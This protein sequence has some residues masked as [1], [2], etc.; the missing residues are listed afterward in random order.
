MVETYPRYWG[1]HSELS[2]LYSSMG[3]FQQAVE[4]AETA[5]RFEPR[6]ESPR[7]NLMRAYIGLDRFADAAKALSEARKIGFGGAKLH[8]IA[9]EAAYLREDAAA[10]TQE[11]AWFAGRPEEYL[12][13]GAQAV[14]ADAL[15]SR[16]EASALYQRAAELAQQHG[17][18]D[19]RDDYEDTNAVAEAATGNCQ[20]VA[21]TGRPALALALCGDAAGAEKLAAATSRQ[22]PNGTLWNAAHLPAIRAAIHIKIGHPEK[23]SDDLAPATSYERVS[24]EAPYLRAIAADA[25]GKPAEAEAEYRKLLDHPGANLGVFYALAR[26]KEGRRTEPS[27]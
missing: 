22:Q 26:R 15:G 17:L 3:Q 23:V 14:R 25:S 16:K 10:A 4:E 21:R 24:P 11:L 7:R 1:S 13:F 9:L 6:A 5:I 2:L 27:H 18:K 19:A 12:S 8:A 20:S